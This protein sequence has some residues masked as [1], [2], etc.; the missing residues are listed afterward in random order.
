MPYEVWALNPD[1]GKLIWHAETDLD[2]NVAPSPVAGDGIVHVTGGFRRTGSIA[3]RAGG[4]GDVTKTHVLW[5][6]REGSYVP[7]PL[8]HDGHLYLVSDQGVAC[9]FEAGTGSV[10]YLERLGRRGR[11]GFG[12]KPFYA[13]V[14]LVDGRLYAVSRRNG[15]FVLSAKPE[16][17][18]LALNKFE[19]D[20]SDFNATPAISDSQVFLRSNRFL[21]CVAASD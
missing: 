2:G 18:R 5:S 9:C 1:T 17:E 16:F 10:L 4:K 8:V 15:T 19:S 13:S 14:V 21:Y 3:I 11:G 20:E 12:D 6:G 7:S